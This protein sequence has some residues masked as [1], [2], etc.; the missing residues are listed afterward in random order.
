MKEYRTVAQWGEREFIEKK[1]RFIGFAAP[2]QSEEEALRLLGERRALHREASHNVWAYV[3]RD[4]QLRRYSDDG[5]PQ[6][7]AGIPVL[8]VLL[9]GEFLNI[10]VV[11]TR[12]FGGTLLGA[13]GLVRAYSHTAKLAVDAAGARYMTPC[14]VFRLKMD[15]SWYGKITYFL[16]EFKTVVLD[17]QF[18]EV[19]TM[20]L[21]IPTRDCPRFLKKLEET[22]FGSIIPE[23]IE[24]NYAFV[25][26]N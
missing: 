10:L 19:V 14:T 1:S 4:A 17:T 7:T 18:A 11:V 9:K 22:S 13:G 2:V 15:Y 8:D 26:E 5:E 21:R 16:P 3:L 23:K 24:E 12:Y 20:M 25:E 6:G